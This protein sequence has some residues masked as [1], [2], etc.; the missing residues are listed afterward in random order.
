MTKFF[1]KS[2]STI[3]V[4]SLV[5]KS[6]AMEFFFTEL[7]K[8]NLDFQIVFLNPKA[9][10]IM[11]ILED[12]GANV[13]WI[14]YAGKKNIPKTFIKL[15]LMLKSIKPLVL[16]AHLFDASIISLPIALLLNI[17]KR[18]HTRHHSSHHHLYFPHAVKYDRFINFCSTEIFAISD[19]VKKVLIEKEHVQNKK[20]KVVHHGF[21]FSY[22]NDVSILRI[23]DIKVRYN[24]ENYGPIVGVISRFTHW[25][26]VQYIIDAF[27]M[28]VEK[29]PKAILVLANAKGDYEKEILHKLKNVPVENYRLINFEADSPALFKSFDVFVHTPIDFHSEAFGQVY[30][31]A[32]MAKVPSVFT[33]SGI[34]NEFVV[35]RKNAL[36]VDYMNPLAIYD[37]LL[38]I[39]DDHDETKIMI[40]QGYDDVLAVF[41][42]TKMVDNSISSYEK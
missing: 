31:E 26:G 35:H 29:S 39:F 1:V 22:F 20:V 17:K 12:K 34:A 10:P 25:K 38:Q 4:I 37:S 8:R 40:Q 2:S 27:Q 21:D 28:F 41:N 42:V 36:V 33:L 3:Y 23:K 18:I 19:N 15:F 32:L 7:L 11:S 9:P 14:K 6:L 5:E 16:H 24:L 30:I 13:K